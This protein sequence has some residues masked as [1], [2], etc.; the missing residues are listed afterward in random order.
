[1]ATEGGRRREREEV[2]NEARQSGR[3][4]RSGRPAK[5]IRPNVAALR[6]GKSLPPW[7]GCRLGRKIAEEMHQPRVTEAGATDPG[8][9]PRG[10]LRRWAV[11]NPV[12]RRRKLAELQ[13][14]GGSA[15][16]APPAGLEESWA[17]GSAVWCGRW[18]LD[19]RI[20]SETL[21]C[22]SDCGV[23]GGWRARARRKEELQCA[24]RVKAGAL[25]GK[26]ERGAVKDVEVVGHVEVVAGRVGLHKL[27]LIDD[28]FYP[29][30]HRGDARCAPP[31]CAVEGRGRV[32]CGLEP[33]FA[34]GL[35][36]IFLGGSTGM[37]G[38]V[39]RGAT[40]LGKCRCRSR[41][42]GSAGRRL[43]RSPAGSRCSCAVV[44]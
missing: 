40:A 5:V 6:D 17:S 12:V 11:V 9:G 10:P 39:S 2:K 33:G 25:Q 14:A 24:V 4:A 38:R 44:E 1:M 23:G 35:V 42:W 32:E 8:G 15:S 29:L 28:H 18:G 13:G 26:A 31:A 22:G 27:E 19:R 20:R 37:N 30:R 34:D 21:G 41:I 3:K 16:T 7:R 36:R 43:S